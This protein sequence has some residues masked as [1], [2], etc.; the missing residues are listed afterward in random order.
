[1]RLGQTVALL[2]L[3]RISA[4]NTFDNPQENTVCNGIN[5]KCGVF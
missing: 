4:R 5:S 3:Y 2:R 1:M